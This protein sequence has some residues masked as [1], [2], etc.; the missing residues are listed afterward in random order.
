[1]G[2]LSSLLQERIIMDI[3]SSPR[4]TRS[5]NR[6]A[7][8]RTGTGVGVVS[9]YIGLTPVES[10]STDRDVEDVGQVTAENEENDSSVTVGVAVNDTDVA[11]AN[12]TIE[13]LDDTEDLSVIDLTEEDA[14]PDRSRMTISPIRLGSHPASL[15]QMSNNFKSSV[16]KFLRDCHFEQ[17]P[18]S[19]VEKVTF[20]NIRDLWDEKVGRSLCRSEKQ[21][22]QELSRSLLGRLLA[23]QLIST[24]VT[25]DLTDSPVK[26]SSEQDAGLGL[27]CPVC[28][29][30]LADLKKSGISALATT[31][32]H[33]FCSTCLPASLV[34][35]AGKCPT[36]RHRISKKDYH[37]IFI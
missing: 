37:K 3:N 2:L 19:E 20:R 35:G 21:V 1:M 34:A 4:R 9:A 23:D 6:L 18:P 17:L 31:C 29:D 5:S 25:V 22:L 26:T 33:I 28:L 11:S 13:L 12:D 30:P 8:Q 15:Q 24:A 36:C 10:T 16:R 14:A 7:N 32:G 27:Q